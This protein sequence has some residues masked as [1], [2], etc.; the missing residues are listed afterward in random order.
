MEPERSLCSLFTGDI[1]PDRDVGLGAEA[2]GLGDG[3]DMR[4]RCEEGGTLPGPDTAGSSGKGCSNWRGGV[5]G[6]WTEGSG[7]A[8][9]TNGG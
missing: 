1:R 6:R 7:T 2:R 4:S 5:T 3:L 9:F 8:S